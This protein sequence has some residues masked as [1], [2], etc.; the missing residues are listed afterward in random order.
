MINHYIVTIAHGNMRYQY[1]KLKSPKPLTKKEAKRICSNQGI[2]VLDRQRKRKEKHQCRP[3]D[4]R[5]QMWKLV[6]EV[7]E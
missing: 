4:C 3:Q 7:V 6:A 2:F 1:S 5:V